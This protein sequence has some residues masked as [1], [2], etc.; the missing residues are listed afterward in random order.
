MATPV[1][2]RQT[3]DI[4]R[5]TVRMPG[6]SR[7]T[8]W[9]KEMPAKRPGQR[10]LLKVNDQGECPVSYNESTNVE[11]TTKHFFVCAEANVVKTEK[12]YY[13]LKYGELEVEGD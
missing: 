13:S 10:V 3:T 11:T 6:N 1:E 12:A 2:Y 7:K 9:A 4:V 8:F 5:V